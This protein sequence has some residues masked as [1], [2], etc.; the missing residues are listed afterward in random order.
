M[1]ELATFAVLIGVGYFVGSQ[2]EAEHFKDLHRRE[3]K[4]TSIQIRSCKKITGKVSDAQMVMASVVVANDYFK[5]AMTSLISIFG[6]QI[7]SQETLLDRARREATLRLLAKAQT[8]GAHEVAGFRMD[9]SMID[10]SGVEVF[11]YGTAI[12]R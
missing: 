5:M 12:K 10:S 8:W 7:R 9:T 6:G 2:R 4:F 11:V 3:K 1:F